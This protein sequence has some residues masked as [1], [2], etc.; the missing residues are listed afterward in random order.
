MFFNHPTI[1]GASKNKGYPKMDGE[2]NGKH[3]IFYWM[4]WGVVP[5]IFGKHPMF[6]RHQ[7]KDFADASKELS[8]AL[9]VG[10]VTSWWITCMTWP[11]VSKTTERQHLIWAKQTHRRCLRCLVEKMGNGW[12]FVNCSKVCGIEIGHVATT[13]VLRF[14]RESAS[15][16]HWLPS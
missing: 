12:W 15:T 5:P 8:A 4:I 6:N 16:L 7:G 14:L 3:P 11:I 1:L 2:K 9:E 13:H 10:T